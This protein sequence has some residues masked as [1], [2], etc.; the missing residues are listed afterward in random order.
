MT[1]QPGRQG[2]SLQNGEIASAEEEEVSY[3]TRRIGYSHKETEK[4]SRKEAKVQS[5]RSRH[6]R[7][8]KHKSK[9][10]S[11]H[12]A[13]SSPIHNFSEE[14]LT[15]TKEYFENKR[16]M[17]QRLLTGERNANSS[18]A[19]VHS[20]VSVCQVKSVSNN[21]ICSLGFLFR[22]SK[23]EATVDRL[24]SKRIGSRHNLEK[25]TQ[26]WQETERLIQQID[27]VRASQVENV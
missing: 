24:S 18:R 8:K 22:Y 19:Y 9:V 3:S 26:Q 17:L 13:M 12:S 11:Q 23:V 20:C 6:H 14:E 2:S 25:P 5:H 21:M 7:R 15:V 1:E 16:L 10:V 4:K 27:E